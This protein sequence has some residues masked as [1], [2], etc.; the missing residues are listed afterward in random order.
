MQTWFGYGAIAFGVFGLLGYALRPAARKAPWYEFLGAALF[1]IVGGILMVTS[2]HGKA[3]TPEV[4][5][6][7]TQ[8][9]SSQEDA[10]IDTAHK[11]IAEQ[12]PADDKEIVA[13]FIKEYKDSFT[14]RIVTL[15]MF[16]ALVNENSY[17]DELDRDTFSN[18]SKL[19]VTH[20]ENC[21][22]LWKVPVTEI[23]N[24]QARKNAQSA[25]E[26]AETACLKM[27]WA[28]VT[29]LATISP[30]FLRSTGGTVGQHAAAVEE[31][32][33]EEVRAAAQREKAE[34]IPLFMAALSAL[35]MDPDLE[36]YQP[37]TRQPT[38]SAKIMTENDGQ[39]L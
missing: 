21:S 38:G 9:D 27:H 29:T 17:K 25:A 24:A 16:D 33:I 23:E 2:D 28:I 15:K 10:S 34:I 14:K 32:M 1:F 6:A 8:E 39:P 26:L 4:A 5:S 31:Q 19:V 36:S 3:N 12:R 20:G 13:T 7:P 18:L 11:G 35:G 22:K 37:E 30:E